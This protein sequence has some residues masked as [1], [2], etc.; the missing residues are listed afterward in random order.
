MQVWQKPYPRKDRNAKYRIAEII[1]PS[2]KPFFS[3]VAVKK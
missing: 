2:L 3:I 1:F